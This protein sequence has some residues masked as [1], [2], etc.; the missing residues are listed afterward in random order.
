MT[1]ADLNTTVTIFVQ[2]GRQYVAVR[3]GGGVFTNGKRL[4]ESGCSASTAPSE[5]LPRSASAV[6]A[7]ATGP[8]ELKGGAACVPCVVSRAKAGGGAPLLGDDR[9]HIVSILTS[10]R[11]NMLAF[12]FHR[13]P[14]AGHIASYFL[15]RLGVLQ[16]S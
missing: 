11:N 12:A 10:G 9:Y 7:D 14:Y 1:D 13:D 16:R 4:V 3:A 6:P 8:P 15:Q 2:Q 5:A